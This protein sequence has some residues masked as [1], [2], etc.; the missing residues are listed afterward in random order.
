MT[1]AL[2]IQV[3]AS[4][5][6][7]IV[8]TVNG[9]KDVASWYGDIIVVATKNPT[10]EKLMDLAITALKASGKE[11]MIDRF[12]SGHFKKNAIKVEDVFVAFFK[13]V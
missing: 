9:G 13:I 7:A 4:A 6:K 5:L 1:N 8:S 11:W 2:N 10:A 3:K 12:Q